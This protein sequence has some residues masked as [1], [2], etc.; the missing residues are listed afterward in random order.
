[1]PYYIANVCINIIFHQ[2]QNNMMMRLLSSLKDTFSTYE[3]YGGRVNNS[4]AHIGT[5]ATIIRK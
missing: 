2:A 4:D 3:Q 5:N 1:M